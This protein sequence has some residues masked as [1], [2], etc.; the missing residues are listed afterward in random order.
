MRGGF[1]VFYDLGSG[2]TSN[3]FTSFPFVS[4]KSLSFV[5]FPLSDADATPPPFSL[6]PPFGS[7]TAFDP[8]LKL[9]RTYQWNFTVEQ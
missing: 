6:E 9:P 1:G 4:Q 3:A 7:V 2:S 5:P 8:E